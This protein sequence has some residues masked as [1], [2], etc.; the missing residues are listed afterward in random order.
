[1][2]GASDDDALFLWDLLKPVVIF[3]IQR[4]DRDRVLPYQSARRRRRTLERYGFGQIQSD[5]SN[6]N[7]DILYSHERPA[8]IIKRLTID[9]LNGTPSRDGRDEAIRRKNRSR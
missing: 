4:E 7:P 2:S 5:V 8:A 6:K 3:V 9:D 1:S